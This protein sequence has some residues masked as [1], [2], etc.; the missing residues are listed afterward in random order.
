MP[1]TVPLGGLR[2]SSSIVANDYVTHLLLQEGHLWGG[3]QVAIPIIVVIGVEDGIRLSISKQEVKD[4]PSVN[5]VHPNHKVVTDIFD[6][7]W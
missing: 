5:V 7:A 6:D 3:K 1:Q 4:L 2:G